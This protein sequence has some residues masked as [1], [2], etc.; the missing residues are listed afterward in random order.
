MQ[1]RQDSAKG[2]CDW[3]LSEGVEYIHA[4]HRASSRR[5]KRKIWAALGTGRSQVRSEL[6]SHLNPTCAV[7]L[8][9]KEGGRDSVGI[10]NSLKLRYTFIPRVLTKHLLCARHSGD[11]G[12]RSPC[13]DSH[14]GEANDRQPNEIDR[15]QFQSGWS[16]MLPATLRF[17]GRMWQWSKWPVQRPTGKDPAWGVG[18][19]GTNTTTT[20]TTPALSTQ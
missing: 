18:E 6:L 19:S 2:A 13:C 20:T 17:R 14:L 15:C 10:M 9:E 11:Q 7:G 12:V 1:S 16:G 5:S 4:L 3:C 8:Q